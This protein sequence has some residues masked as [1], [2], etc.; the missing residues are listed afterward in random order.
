MKTTQSPAACLCRQLPQARVLRATLHAVTRDVFRFLRVAGREDT[1]GKKQQVLDACMH[2]FPL[3]ASQFRP[4]GGHSASSPRKPFL[5]FS[6]LF[7]AV[8]LLVCFLLSVALRTSATRTYA[9]G[10]CRLSPLFRLDGGRNFFP[11]LSIDEEARSLQRPGLPPPAQ[12]KTRAA[13]T[14]EKSFSKLNE[15]AFFSL[16]TSRQTRLRETHLP[17]SAPERSQRSL[18]GAG[19]SAGRSAP[20]SFLSG[21]SRRQVSPSLA[22]PCE[23]RKPGEGTHSLTAIDA[24]QPRRVSQSVSSLPRSA[25][26]SPAVR[27]TAG[28]PCLLKTL[29][30]QAGP[31]F[32][33]PRTRLASASL[34]LPLYCSGPRSSPPKLEPVEAPEETG[35]RPCDERKSLK[36]TREDHQQEEGRAAGDDSERLRLSGEYVFSLLC[37]FGRL[38]EHAGLHSWGFAANPR[39][40]YRHLHPSHSLPLL[41]STP[42]AN[43][44]S[45]ASSSSSSSSSADPSD[46]FVSYLDRLCR[47]GREGP[48]SHHRRLAAE[49]ALFL[50]D[51][52]LERRDAKADAEKKEPRGSVDERDR[53]EEGKGDR[54]EEKGDRE[55]TEERDVDGRVEG[56]TVFGGRQDREDERGTVGGRREER[57]SPGGRDEERR[58]WHG[59]GG[60]E[61]GHFYVRGPWYRLLKMKLLLVGF[62]RYRL[63][64]G[65][66]LAP[67]AAA[68]LLR[69]RRGGHGT[70]GHGGEEDWPS[71]VSSSFLLRPPLSLP[72]S[73]LSSFTLPS[74]SSLSS[75][76]SSLSSRSAGSGVRRGGAPVGS[77][78]DEERQRR[79]ET[80]AERERAEELFD[81]ALPRGI[82]ASVKHALFREEALRNSLPWEWIHPQIVH[83]AGEIVCVGTE[84]LRGS[85]AL[86]L[87]LAKT[88]AP[89][90]AADLSQRRE[91]QDRLENVCPSSSSLSRASPFPHSASQV[92]TVAR[93]VPAGPSSS[94]FPAMFATSRSGLGTHAS[95]AAPLF[96]EPLSL[97]QGK[98]DR[99]RQKEELQLLQ[100]LQQLRLSARDFFVLLP[101]LPFQFP[102]EVFE[103]KASEEE[104]KNFCFNLLRKRLLRAELHPCAAHGA[105][106][107]SGAHGGD[108]T[109]ARRG[110]RGNAAKG[111]AASLESRTETPPLL[112]G[113]QQLG[114]EDQQALLL[115]RDSRGGPQEAERRGEDA[116]E[117]RREERLAK[118]TRGTAGASEKR[119]HTLADRQN[120]QRRRR[121]LLGPLPLFNLFVQLLRYSTSS[122]RSPGSS[123]ASSSSSS[124]SSSPSPSS[125][126]SSFSSSPC[127]G[128]ADGG[129]LSAG[130]SVETFSRR[131][132]ARVADFLIEQE[133]QRKANWQD[134]WVALLNAAVQRFSLSSRAS[135]LAVQDVFEWLRGPQRGCRKPLDSLFLSDDEGIPP[136]PPPGPDASL[137]AY[138]FGRGL[139]GLPPQRKTRETASPSSL[140]EASR[141]NAESELET[142]GEKRGESKCRGLERGEVHG[143]AKVEGREPPK[144][145]DGITFDSVQATIFDAVQG[146]E[147]QSLLW[148]EFLRSVRRTGKRIAEAEE[149]RDD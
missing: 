6:S 95:A 12:S 35:A 27:P 65:P 73:S 100:R 31:S 93:E 74:S 41:S 143:P 36:E 86:L 133:L 124:S 15:A 71:S 121:S 8:C 34:R 136:P 102:F 99:E 42:Q 52:S 81:W 141:D 92:S 137:C 149:K 50:R 101:H 24:G 39:L 110:H 33:L 105:E 66:T 47:L 118:E 75:S 26:L 85:E 127:V 82:P 48:G 107:E 62:L 125:S 109:L 30:T 1:L 83:A 77:T 68:G 61:K 22:S 58:D 49:A 7:L 37:I 87:L 114:G 17:V 29:R 89:C 104:M 44:I 5:R 43:H 51:V 116:E 117:V 56:Q 108:G 111:D 38:A 25:S 147:E 115:P 20:V 69:P 148:P 91:Q 3:D 76:S 94:S 13:L 72:S 112:Q 40:E 78:G 67:F 53:E 79:S 46:A 138:I 59:E 10:R 120:V 106:A 16:R 18:V 64:F 103:E 139:A 57:I 98:K 96:P 4:P 54:E 122:D 28:L 126:S 140:D 9:R 63:R 11:S 88:C 45:T 113:P 142:S 132:Y 60:V 123:L 134:A 23:R 146:E 144:G 119:E 130:V 70:R 128:S 14:P 2:R 97:P 131:C 19:G 21:F 32:F 135:R 84:R 80:D 55:E 145:E 90:G 129:V